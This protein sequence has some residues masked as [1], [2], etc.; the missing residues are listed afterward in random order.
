ML[1]YTTPFPNAVL[2]LVSSLKE[3]E[4]RTLIVVVGKTLGWKDP[5]TK[6]GRK[7]VDYIASSQFEKDGGVG[8]RALGL[9][10]QSL[11]AKG[12]IIALDSRGTV[13]DTPAKRKGKTRIYYR[14]SPTLMP[15][16]VD[17]AEDIR[18]RITGLAHQKRIT[19]Y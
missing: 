3:A 6:T 12:Y 14:L 13:L 8:R 4:L 17:R 19:Q 1:Y 15:A 18:R 10:T 9:A 2:Q 11:I 7:E 16:C 5:H